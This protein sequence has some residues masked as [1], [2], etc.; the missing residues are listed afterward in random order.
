LQPNYDRIE[1]L[2]KQNKSTQKEHGKDVVKKRPRQT[3]WI[4]SWK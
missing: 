1:A 2:I 4:N 3:G